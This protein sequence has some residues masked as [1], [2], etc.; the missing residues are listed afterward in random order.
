MDL[1]LQKHRSRILGLQ[2][3]CGQRWTADLKP[4]KVGAPKL[5]WEP[6]KL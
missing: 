5:V 2:P 6:L 4:H 3:V 1:Q